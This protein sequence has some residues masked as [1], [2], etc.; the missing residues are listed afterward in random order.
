MFL[1]PVKVNRE[2]QI[3]SPLGTKAFGPIRAYAGFDTVE[4]NRSFSTAIS[5]VAKACKY[6]TLP[7]ITGLFERKYYFGLKIK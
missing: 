6:F 7:K 5:C 4:L 3:L 1:L 2:V